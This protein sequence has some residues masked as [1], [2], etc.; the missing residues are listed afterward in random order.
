MRS[1]IYLVLKNLYRYLSSCVTVDESYHNHIQNISSQSKFREQHT[2]TVLL[3][4][5]RPSQTLLQVYISKKV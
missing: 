2:K 4:D 3:F 5:L 1:Y